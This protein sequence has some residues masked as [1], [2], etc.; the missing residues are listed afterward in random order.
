M[1]HRDLRKSMSAYFGLHATLELC[2]NKRIEIHER[3]LRVPYG[4]HVEIEDYAGR[5]SALVQYL[6]I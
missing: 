5:L 3:G 4:R 1:L 2:A 6:Y